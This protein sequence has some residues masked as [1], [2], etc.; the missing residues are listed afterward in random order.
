VVKIVVIELDKVVAIVNVELV[1][2]ILVVEIDKLVMLVN[3]LVGVDVVELICVIGSQSL[4][5]EQF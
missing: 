2:D 1:P 3:S 4:A 5:V